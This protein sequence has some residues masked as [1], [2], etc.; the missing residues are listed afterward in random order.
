[1]L[2]REA[3]ARKGQTDSH[4]FVFWREPVYTVTG[5]RERARH[6]SRTLTVGAPSPDASVSVSTRLH[7]E[8][9]HKSSS[10]LKRDAGAMQL[11]GLPSYQSGGVAIRTKGMQSVLPGGIIGWGGGLPRAAEAK[12]WAHCVAAPTPHSQRPT[13]GQASVAQLALSSSCRCRMCLASQTCMFVGA[14]RPV[15]GGHGRRAG[16]KHLAIQVSIMQSWIARWECAPH[17]ERSTKA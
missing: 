10:V 4:G 12:G 8:R 3:A 13:V 9:G 7:L 5:T 1:M 2:A 6:A 11:P 17:D 16:D 15:S 14:S